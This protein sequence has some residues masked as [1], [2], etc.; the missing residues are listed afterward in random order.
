[1]TTAARATVETTRPSVCPL[2]CPDRCSLEV[3]VR[4][5]RVTALEGS[6]SNPLTDGFICS[7]VRRFPERVY[8]RD[9]LL[10]PLRRTGPKGE[11]GFERIT[12]G[13]A[14][15][16]IAGR[17]G[18][19]S[20]RWG[21][22]A[23]LPYSYGGN[24]GLVGQ[25]TMDARF[26]SRLGASRLDRAVCAA[27]TGAVAKAMTG[28]MPGVAFADYV[29]ARLILLWGANPWH[30]NIHLVPHLK[31]A[32]EAGA[33]VVLLDPRRTGGGAYVDS[34]L[35]VYPGGDVAVALALIRHLDR[36]GRVAA[37]FL[38]EHA[39][40]HEAVLEVAQGWTFERA[41]EVARVPA[42]E[43]AALAEAYAEADP[44][45]VRIGWGLERNRN[46]GS[47]VAAILALVAV[48]GKLGRRGGGYTLSQSGGFRVDEEHLA[49][50]PEAPTRLLNMNLLGRML[51]GEVP[52]PPIQALFV[53]DCNPVVT[54]PH[55]RAI[56][57][58]LA[59]EDL[60]T[61][62]FDAVMTDTARYAD[63][64]LPAVTFL[65]QSEVVKSYGSFVLQ[66]I[67]PVIPPVG[68]ARPNEDVFRDL[69]ALMGFEEPEFR[70]DARALAER[71]V[72]S[73]RGPLAGPVDLERLDAEGLVPFDF[74]GSSPV[75]FVTA[76]PHTSDQRI[77]LA[78]P[79][80]GPY[81][82]AY[83]DA[84]PDPLHP[85]ALISPASDKT[86]NSVLGELVKDEAHLVIHPDDA[87]ARA[88]G[89]G[90]GVRVFNG[91]AEVHCRARLDPRIRPGV[92]SLPKGYWRRSFGNGLTSTAL[93]PDT[94][95]EIGGGACFNDTRVEV[96]PLATEPLRSA[97]AAS[98]A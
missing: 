95:S 27:P 58:G 60:F 30:S 56:E 13:E 18:E 3:T 47:A 90:D 39:T 75:Q 63:V 2:D 37:A 55:Q 4:D 15:R 29:H 9:R 44:A 33:R 5:G 35:P 69:A 16:L 67:K 76:F 72:A 38:R 49:G 45:V 24:N 12:W 7:K 70:E 88:I 8:G 41:A 79:E 77:H 17:L 11:G 74:P 48:A 80:L 21:G 52:D 86:I 25:G 26:F 66:R 68:E 10:H 61:V 59:R 20:E 36:T 62:V 54:V 50:R 81:V 19:V 6:H 31:A 65:E 89:P 87:R 94:L 64:V 43:I 78:P 93:V 83:R 92:V 28:K 23:I 14:L 85:L 53:Y 91:Q 82:Y 73:V 98:R 46:G 57:R 96:T 42:A 1:M 71:A 32:R 22:E 40:G 97:P 84:L 34:W 51:L